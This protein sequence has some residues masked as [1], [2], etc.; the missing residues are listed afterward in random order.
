MRARTYADS[1]GGWVT[2]V[3]NRTAPPAE[4]K[5]IALRNFSVVLAALRGEKFAKEV[6]AAISPTLRDA[7]QTGKIVPSGWYPLEWYRELHAG[8]RRV[9]GGEPGV[10]WL[11][12]REST[13]HDMTGIYR[14]FLR[15]VSPHYI[16]SAGSRIFGTYYRPG[17]MRV[18]ESRGGFSRVA[19]ENCAGFDRHVWNDVLGGCEVS[20]ELAG[21]RVVRVHLESGGHDGDTEAVAVAWWSFDEA[22]AH[23]EAKS[24]AGRD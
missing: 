6:L 9:T 13:K 23:R 2:A 19:F 3:G 11:I 20:L 7:L 5:G 12:G 16:L 1:V 24:D 22:S 17:T 4:V 8:V 14:I 18:L 21:A 15:I 10:A